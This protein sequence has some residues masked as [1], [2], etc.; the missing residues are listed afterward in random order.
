M[1][2]VAYS[3]S[4]K[5]D[6]IL[7]SH[8]ETI[9]FRTNG[10]NPFF[11]NEKDIIKL[12]QH[13]PTIQ[14][15][16]DKV[17]ETHFFGAGCLSPDLRERIS[18][19]L[20]ALFRN[21][22]IN[23]E[24]DILGVSYATC[25]HTKGISCIL[26]TGSNSVYFDGSNTYPSKFGLGYILGDEGSGAFFGKKLIKDFLYGT[27]PSR[28]RRSFGNTYHLNKEIIVRHVYQE[29]SPSSYLGSFAPFMSQHLDAPYIQHLIY[30]GFEKFINT[31]I[32]CFDNYNQYPCHFTGSI[33]YYFKDILHTVCLA[34][35][36]NIGQI[37]HR[38]TERLAK[39]IT[40]IQSTETLSQVL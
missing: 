13:H 30:S 17:T 11:L 33:A 38:P 32:R 35:R 27:M 31:N 14:Q 26:G 2:L 7:Q 22:F 6:W 4:S 5:A 36:I 24:Q 15:I 29:S 34:N 37:L 19:A 12:L 9:S 23:V 21:A 3:G 1:I 28:L 20:S 25:G 18:N 16:Q 8:P 40:N 10:L 39:F